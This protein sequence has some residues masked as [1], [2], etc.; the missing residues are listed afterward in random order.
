MGA[1]ICLKKKAKIKYCQ[2][3]KSAI[4]MKRFFGECV[5]KKPMFKSKSSSGITGSRMVMNYWKI[6]YMPDSPQNYGTR[7]M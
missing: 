2:F 6:R 1:M 3:W 4:N 7:T 5:V